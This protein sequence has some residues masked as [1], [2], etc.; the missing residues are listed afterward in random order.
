MTII[1]YILI[2]RTVQAL[3]FVA[4][5]LEFCLF[6]CRKIDFHI[7]DKQKYFDVKVTAIDG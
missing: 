6:S 1:G 3:K 5:G 7:G 4:V 2:E